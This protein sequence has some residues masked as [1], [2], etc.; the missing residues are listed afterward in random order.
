MTKVNLN[1]IYAGTIEKVF[2][3]KS[4]DNLYKYQYF[5]KVK[6]TL[7]SFSQVPVNCV[8]SE[9]FGSKND[10]EDTILEV[11]CRVLVT[12]LNNDTTLGVILGAIRLHQTPVNSD[13]GKHYK[14][15]YNDIEEFISSNKNYSLTSLKNNVNFQ[16]N[17][18][19]IVLDDNLNDKIIIDRT[20][21]KITIEC[22]TWNVT[23]RGNA[24]INVS[25]NANISAK[26]VNI[27]ASGDAN[28]TSGGITNV[29][30]SIIK[31]NGAAGSVMTDVLNPV[32]D[33]ITGVPSVGVKNVKSG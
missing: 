29:K 20:N 10:F 16:L 31:L 26:N 13:L 6:I 30:A 33:L 11:G 1:K 7:D 14:K 23:V 32:V 15:R 3:T 4:T 21:K 8:M 12:F 24:T 19:S 17:T 5:Y 27:S 18:E 2:S 25:G 9:K 22:E 28:L